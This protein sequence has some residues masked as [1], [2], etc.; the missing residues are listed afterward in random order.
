MMYHP[1]TFFLFYFVMLLRLL[2]F[3]CRRCC[4]F[5]ACKLAQAS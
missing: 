4:Q 1:F 3:Y 5:A 2:L